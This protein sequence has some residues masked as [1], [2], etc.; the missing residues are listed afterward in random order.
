MIDY[1]TKFQPGGESKVKTE[2]SVI[3]YQKIF[4]HIQQMRERTDKLQT[5]I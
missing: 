2:A 3:T 5:M 1:K 4:Q